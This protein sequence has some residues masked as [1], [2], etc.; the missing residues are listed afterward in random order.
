VKIGRTKSVLSLVG[1]KL[2]ATFDLLSSNGTLQATTNEL[3]ICARGM[4]KYFLYCNC[5][6]IIACDRCE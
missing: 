1:L 3:M 5:A 4:D 6:I 2:G